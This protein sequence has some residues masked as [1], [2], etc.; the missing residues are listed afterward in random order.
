MF[1][2]KMNAYL[3]EQ[4]RLCE[5]RAEVLAGESREDEAVFEK[6]RL[7]VFDIFRTVLSAA[8]TATDSQE[9]AVRFFLERLRRIP[10][11]WEKS[12]AAA[13]SHGDEAKAHI[14]KLKLDAVAR[15][16]QEAEKMEERL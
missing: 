11:A 9:E 6:I 15:I 5:A 16:R 12:L 1:A 8:K 7:N 14:E 13:Q 3:L 4:R 10:A 2:E